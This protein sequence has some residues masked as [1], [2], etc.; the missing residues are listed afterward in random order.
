MNPP[1]LAQVSPNP[2]IPPPTADSESRNV[3]LARVYSATRQAINPSSAISPSLLQSESPTIKF[4]RSVY[5]HAWTVPSENC[6]G[7]KRNRQSLSTVRHTHTPIT[8]LRCVLCTQANCTG[9]K[10]IVSPC[11]TVQ[12]RHIP[13]RPCVTHTHPQQ[14][15]KQGP[16]TRFPK[17]KINR[18]IIP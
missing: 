14:N 2:P 11:R 18:K 4:C 15:K 9:T 12:Y 7:A 13:I 5:T 16:E 6:T 17:I 3:E 8:Q 10:T 1:R